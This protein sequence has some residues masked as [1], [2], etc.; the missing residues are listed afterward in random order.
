MIIL[1][2]GSTMFAMSVLRTKSYEIVSYTYIVQLILKFHFQI[3]MILAHDVFSK[4]Q[5]I[6]ILKSF[7]YTYFISQFAL[8]NRTELVC[9][10][11]R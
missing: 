9:W 10:V 3:L 6:E 7:Y 11:I 8:M 4:N 2:K 5:I 1:A